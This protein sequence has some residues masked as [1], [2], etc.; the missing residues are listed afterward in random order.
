MNY[1]RLGQRIHEIRTAC[2][3][4][5][6]ELARHLVCSP[7]HLSNIERGVSRPSLD[8]LLDISSALHVSIEF[9][10]SD[11]LFPYSKSSYSDVILQVDQFLDTQQKEIQQLRHVLKQT[12]L[13]DENQKTSNES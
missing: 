13:Q 2:N 3:I 12:Y 9:L 6:K 7:K 11:S 4:S 1:Y 10:L 8:C 5:Q